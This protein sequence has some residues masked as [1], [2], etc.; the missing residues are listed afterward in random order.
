MEHLTR[1]PPRTSS[2]WGALALSVAILGAAGIIS[3]CKGGDDKKPDEAPAVA[4]T[5]P[6][7]GELPAAGDVAGDSKSANPGAGKRDAAPHIKT[8]AAEPGAAAGD[9]PVAGAPATVTARTAKQLPGRAAAAGPMAR[10]PTTMRRPA[11]ALRPGT[12]DGAAAAEPTTGAA[13]VGDADGAE[14]DGAEPG[15]PGG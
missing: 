6:E 7:P 14:D 4:L 12:P 3:G 8:S 11:A 9:V 2:T 10:T 1:R 15:A 13:L 5:T